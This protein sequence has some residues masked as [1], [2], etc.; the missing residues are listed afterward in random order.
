M[1][2]AY[3]LQLTREKTYELLELTL[4]NGA[5]PIIVLDDPEGIAHELFIDLLFADRKDTEIFNYSDFIMNQAFSMESM[6]ELAKRRYIVVE[7]V[8]YLYGKSATSKIL[9]DF[10]EKMLASDTGVIFV[11]RHAIM[12][13]AEFI[14]QAEDSVQ[15]VIAL[16]LEGSGV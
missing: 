9:A 13:M 11:G 5:H 4:T 15:Y 16:D 10:A 1:G 3:N 8:K 14:E 6:N 2:L 7:D 12:D